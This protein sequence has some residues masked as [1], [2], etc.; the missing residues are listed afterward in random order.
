VQQ[1][2]CWGLLKVLK[3]E[4]QHSSGL[5]VGVIWNVI[6][7]SQ[8]SCIPYSIGRMQWL[9][10]VCFM[11]WNTCLVQAALLY[12]R[13]WTPGP[14]SSC[15]AALPRPGSEANKPFNAWLLALEAESHDPSVM[16]SKPQFPL[17]LGTSVS[18]YF[19]VHMMRGST[20]T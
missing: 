11:D 15:L 3:I 17:F 9:V 4:E 13:F 14:G 8:L 19:H 1:C 2:G 10:S 20:Q 7:V 5:R 16:T 18:S 6:S 12:V